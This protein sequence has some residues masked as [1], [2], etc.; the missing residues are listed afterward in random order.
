VAAAISQ[1]Y[2]YDKKWERFVVN[3]GAGGVDALTYYLGEAPSQLTSSDQE[4]FFAELF[5]DAV[6]VG[7]IVL[8]SPYVAENFVFEADVNKNDYEYTKAAYMRVFLKSEPS[9]S[10]MFQYGEVYFGPSS[11]L[12]S[13]Q[14]F[15]LLYSMA[16]GIVDLFRD[17][18]NRSDAK[19]ITP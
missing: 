13:S 9:V 10:G 11:T 15:H 8:P 5:T 18:L 19:L 2:F 17:G 7:A 16:G 6:D 14:F 4:K 1:V 3:S 12:D